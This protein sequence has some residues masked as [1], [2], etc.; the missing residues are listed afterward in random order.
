M[1]CLR[2]GPGEYCAWGDVVLSLI[3]H[4]RG[5]HVKPLYLD[6]PQLGNSKSDSL[7]GGSVPLGKTRP[8]D[9]T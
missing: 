9:N 6:Q 5:L 3:H 4:V 8:K 2:S 1:A 7:L